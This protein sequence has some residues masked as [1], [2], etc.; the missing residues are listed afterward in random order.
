MISVIS[1]STEGFGMNHTEAY[2]FVRNI[3][4]YALKKLQNSKAEG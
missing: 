2:K 3:Y 4:K 1:T